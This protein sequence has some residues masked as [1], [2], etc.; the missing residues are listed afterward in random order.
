MSISEETPLLHEAQQDVENAHSNE[1]QDSPGE[2]DSPEA[3]LS[4]I[5]VVR[6]IILTQTVA[7]QLNERFFG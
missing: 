6:S 3:K 2:G 1:V 4:A 7:E 5:A